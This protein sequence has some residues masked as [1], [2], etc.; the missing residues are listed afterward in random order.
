MTQ[1]I[2]K[3]RKILREMLSWFLVVFT[4][5][6]LAFLLRNFVIVN[7]SVPTGSMRDTIPER[8]RIVISR[9]AY[10]FSDPQRFDVVVFTSPRDDTTLYVKR[11]VGMP[12]DT[13][14]ILGGV[15]HINGEAI[16]EDYIRGEPSPFDNH[17]PF[18]VPEGSF[19]MLGDYRDI[20]G[21]SRHWQEPFVHGDT[22]LG[23]AVFSY[24]PSIRAIR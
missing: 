2:S 6:M 20:S 23:R 12:G 11:I 14:E 21:D 1:D 15:V 17:G 24:F 8:S 9:L 16:Y 10:L 4:A 22:I 5:V 19:F 7:A 3:Q 18:F 13:L